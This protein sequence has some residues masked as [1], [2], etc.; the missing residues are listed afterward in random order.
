[1]ERGYTATG[2]H[3]PT[4]G[5][6]L[7]GSVAIHAANIDEEHIKV[8]VEETSYEPEYGNDYNSRPRLRSR[9]NKPLNDRFRGRVL[10]SVRPQTAAIETFKLR[11]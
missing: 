11:Q 3:C 8:I 1:M 2:F 10:Q 9:S 5:L 4:C 7:I 6:A